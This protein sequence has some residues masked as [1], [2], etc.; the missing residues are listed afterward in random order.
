MIDYRQTYRTLQK[1]LESIEHS[2]EDTF[3]LSGIVNAIVQGPGPSLGI[4][5]GRLYRHDPQAGAYVLEVS[6]GQPDR[7]RPGFKVPDDYPPIQRMRREG[8]VIS[9][10]DDPEFDRTIE[11]QIGVQQFASIS[12]GPEAQHLIAFTLA[13]E[14]DP[15]RAIYLLGTIRHVVDLKIATGQMLHDL[16]EARRIQMSLLPERMPEIP[17]FD[18]AARSI[19]AEAVGGD[20]FDFPIVTTATLAV[21]VADS[22]GHGLP[23]AL[24]ARDIVTGLR[25][26]LDVHYR[27]VH[28]IEKVNRVVARSA[29]ASRFI[30]MFYAEIDASG[31]M[32]YCNAGHPPGLLWSDGRIRRLSRGGIVLGPDPEATYERAFE[33][34]PPGAT[35]L[36]YTDGIT[37]AQL[38]GGGLFEVEG[39]ERLLAAHHDQPAALLRDIVFEELDRRTIGPREDDQTLLAIRRLPA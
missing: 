25:V 16:A 34:F 29:L 19:P 5:G 2:A 3:T 35:L 8:L 30:T 24:M 10:E 37:E 38:K 26:A 20:I 23:A 11:Q 32:L 39:L 27:A 28:S 9:G 17:G 4:T 14:V 6:V 21:V 36:L 31:T 18:V 15:Q 12:I 22:S 33:N 13:P 7:V 1:A